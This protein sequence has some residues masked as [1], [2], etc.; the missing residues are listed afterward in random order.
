MAIS[1]GGAPLPVCTCDLDYGVIDGYGRFIG[2]MLRP[3][4]LYASLYTRV[5]VAIA[6]LAPTSLAAELVRSIGRDS[7]TIDRWQVRYSL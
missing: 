6:I 3:W 4:S 7:S 5:V 1:E 2:S